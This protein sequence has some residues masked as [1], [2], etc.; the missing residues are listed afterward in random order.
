MALANKT[1]LIE[2]IRKCMDT[3][4]IDK[5]T[6][7]LQYLNAHLPSEYKVQIPSLIT[8]DWINH[9]LYLLEEKF[10]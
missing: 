9:S 3:K 2:M 10:L 6:L 4:E 1:E 8:N 5:R 7:L